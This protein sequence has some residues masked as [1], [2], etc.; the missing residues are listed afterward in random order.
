MA[1]IFV[2]GRLQIALRRLAFTGPAYVS[3]SANA[4]PTPSAFGHEAERVGSHRL[5]DRLGPLVRMD[6]VQTIPDTGERALGHLS[7]RGF[8]T[9]EAC[10]HVGFDESGVN[11]DNLRALSLQ[12]HSHPFGQCECR[13]F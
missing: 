4:R 11:G 5:P 3:P 2:A 9:V 6:V 10:R 8:F 7:R 12:L 13:V 1:A